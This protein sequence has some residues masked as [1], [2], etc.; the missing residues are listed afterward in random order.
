[1]IPVELEVWDFQ[2]P[3]TS[4]LVTAFGFSG[5]S[6]IRGHYGKYTSDSDIDELTYLYEK[7]ALWHGSCKCCK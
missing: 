5:N 2:L 7:A 3:S 4:T 1:M 6:A